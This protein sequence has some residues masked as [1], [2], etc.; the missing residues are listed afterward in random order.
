VTI[1]SGADAISCVPKPKT[2]YKSTPMPNSHVPSLT[3]A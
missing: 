2:T 3:H 1:L